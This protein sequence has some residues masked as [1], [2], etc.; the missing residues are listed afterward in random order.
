MFIIRRIYC[1]KESRVGYIVSF[2]FFLGVIR[3]FVGEIVK[4]GMEYI[5]FDIKLRLN[6]GR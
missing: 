5:E 6:V 1:Y 3:G 2:L 4:T